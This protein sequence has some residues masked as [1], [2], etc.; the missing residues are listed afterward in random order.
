MLAQENLELKQQV[1]K[2][3]NLSKEDLQSYSGLDKATFDVVLEM[4]D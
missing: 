1:F 4:I 3:S 2:F